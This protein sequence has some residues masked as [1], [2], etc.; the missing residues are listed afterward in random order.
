MLKVIVPPPRICKHLYT[1]PIENRSVTYLTRGPW[2]RVTVGLFTPILVCKANQTI[3]VLTMLAKPCDSSKSYRGL[4]I[5]KQG[6]RTLRI[7]RMITIVDPYVSSP[8]LSPS[9]QRDHLAISIM[10]GSLVFCLSSTTTIFFAYKVM[11]DTEVLPKLHKNF[12]RLESI[13]PFRSIK[14]NSTHVVGRRFLPSKNVTKVP[15]MSI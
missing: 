14:A 10:K 7:V 11:C 6:S 13:E 5:T 8:S 15:H 3:R 12:V 4:P 1:S 2:Q 9:L